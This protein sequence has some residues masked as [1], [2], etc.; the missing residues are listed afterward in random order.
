MNTYGW[1]A[2]VYYQGKMHTKFFPDKKWGGR[3]L[4]L[5]AAIQWRNETEA[6]I[7]KPRADRRVVTHSNKSTGVVGVRLNQIR[8]RYDVSWV[9][10]DG[11][12]NKTSV[13]IGKYGQKAAFK[14]AC[15]IREEKNAQ[16]LAAE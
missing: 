9:T 13:S 11:K 4:S 3:D 8:N 15:K 16:R 5:K 2:R 7:G 6:S 14:R 12:N 1:R 10:A